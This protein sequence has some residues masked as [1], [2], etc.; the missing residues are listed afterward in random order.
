MDPHWTGA[1]LN[2]SPF[3][4]FDPYEGNLASSLVHALEKSSKGDDTELVDFINKN[5][6]VGERLSKEGIVSFSKRE[7]IKWDDAT[8]MF[9]LLIVLTTPSDFIRKLHPKNAIFGLNSQKMVI[10]EGF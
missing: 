2:A 6:E 1:Y 8:I 10:F 7:D 5:P 3:Y 9:V 4:T